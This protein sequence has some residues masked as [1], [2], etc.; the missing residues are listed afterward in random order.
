M[1]I[2]ACNEV[3]VKDLWFSPAQ[4]KRKIGAAKESVNTKKD[5]FSIDSL[6]K[7]VFS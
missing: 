2:L 6:F 5:Q 1:N 7:N 3:H 4:K